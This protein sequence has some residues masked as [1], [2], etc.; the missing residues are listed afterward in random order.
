[1]AAG[2]RIAPHQRQL[3]LLMRLL[4]APQPLS[5]EDILTTVDGYRG[6]PRGDALSKKFERD[7]QA[8]KDAG[9]ELEIVANPTAQDD[10]AQWRFRIADS[11]AGSR[12]LHLSA[13]ETLLVA[14]ATNVWEQSDVAD[15]ARRAFLK[16][17][18]TGEVD[19]RVRD[20]V[21]RASIPVDSAFNDLHLAIVER[22]AV[23][24]DYHRAGATEVTHR[25]VEPL[26]LVVV[27]GHWLCNAFDLDRGSERNFLLRRIT[28]PITL[29]APGTATHRAQTNL[30][31]TLAKL[32][33][34]SPVTIAVQPDSDAEVRLRRRAVRMHP[35][36][37]GWPVVELHSWDH[38]LL[39]NEL[40]SLGEQVRIIAPTSMT[41]RVR[42][43]L[44]RI[45]SLHEGAPQSTGR[46]SNQG[47][48]A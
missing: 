12:T 45:L 36:H 27:D 5:S 29:E 15:E 2:S 48:R 32:A 30:P 34:E 41:E 47:A 8:L 24:F 43:R 16:L 7:R 20:A 46:K 37:E 19:D 4:D 9:I 1:M 6:E 25:H 38:E 13:L 31:E 22:R 28:S 44:D 14:Q 35:D 42:A 17:A 21:R 11:D 23:T 3:S 40:T 39:A 18:R 33:A 26:Q 10:R